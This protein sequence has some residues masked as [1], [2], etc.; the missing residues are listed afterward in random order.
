ME[1]G[2]PHVTTL[3]LAMG[4]LGPELGHGVQHLFLLVDLSRRFSVQELERAA[5]ATVVTFPILSCRQRVSWWRDRWVPDPAHTE[6]DVVEVVEVT[7]DVEEET[8]K[9]TAREL[10]PERGWPWRVTMLRTA[11]GGRLVVTVLHM[12]ADGAGA[13]AIL[14]ELVTRLVEQDDAATANVAL[15]VRRAPDEAEE[16]P[17]PE[18]GAMQLLRGRSLVDFWTLGAELARESARSLLV[19][20]ISRTAEPHS[21]RSGRLRPVF[22]SVSVPI[23][24]GTAFRRRCRELGCTI[25]DAL[26]ATLAMVNGSLSER[27]IVGTFFTVD[28]RRYLPDDRPRIA[29]LSGFDTLLL[30][31]EHLGS[32]ERAVSAVSARTSKR[33]GRFVGLPTMLVMSALGAGWPHAF[34]RAAGVVGTMLFRGFTS[35]GL[36]VTNLGRLDDCLS[37]LGGDALS[38]TVIGPFLR[39][40]RAPIVTASSFRGTLHL[41]IAGYDDESGGFQDR[42]ASEITK[43]LS[44]LSTIE[45]GGGFL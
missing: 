4:G 30:R 37:P 5:A 8:R 43:I 3:D 26:V 11:R 28:L 17:R 29:N 24:E 15:G 45:G 14:R 16:S 36:L 12:A 9:L 6:R 35:R 44:E 32:F 2:S 18:R 38:A 21:V 22:R 20:F 31:R 42:V 1:E 41:E 25:N 27:G 13:L 40:Q 33:K 39:G 34:Q 23:G 10:D 7:T 19:P